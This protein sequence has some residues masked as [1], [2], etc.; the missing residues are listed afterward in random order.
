MHVE[1]DF[2]LKC[3]IG[4]SIFYEKTLP[5][6][7]GFIGSHRPTQKIIMVFNTIINFVLNSYTIA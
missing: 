3:E 1:Q 4:Q 6:D 7:V 2:V 5:F